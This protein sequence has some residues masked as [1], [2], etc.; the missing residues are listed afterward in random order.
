MHP[1]SSWQ[2]STLRLLAWGCLFAI[3][4]SITQ[5]WAYAQGRPG[6]VVS[7]E[8]DSFFGPLLHSLFTF[9]TRGLMVVLSR[10]E[11]TLAAFI[12]LNVIVFVET[13]LL[14]GFFLPGDSLLVITG[15]ICSNPECGW[16]VPL[17]LV[18]LSLSAIVGDSIGYSIGYKTGPKIFNPEKSLLF[19]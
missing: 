11:Y 13:G 14:I 16:S 19:N 8:P 10:P 5:D 4:C 6:Y 7:D 12:A 9:D 17:L 18:T 3:V 15:M 1:F 2:R